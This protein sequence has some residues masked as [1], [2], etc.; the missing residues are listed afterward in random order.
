MRVFARGRPRERLPPPQV[1]GLV[2][3]VVVVVALGAVQLGV[4]RREEAEVAHELGRRGSAG[5]GR[6][7]RR[8]QRRV[9]RCK[10]YLK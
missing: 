10:I 4:G 3:V 5:C 8:C 1:L 9:A 6:R 7:R 2:V